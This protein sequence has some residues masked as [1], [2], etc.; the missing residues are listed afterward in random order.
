MEKSYAAVEKEDEDK[1]EEGNEWDECCLKKSPKKDGKGKEM[2]RRREKEEGEGLER[3]A[4][5]EGVE[6]EVML[7]GEGKGLKIVL[8]GRM[9]EKGREGGKD[10]EALCYCREGGRGQGG[11]RK[12]MALSW[13]GQ[14]VWM[15][16]CCKE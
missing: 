4:G 6:W 10:G 7:K 13:K 16:C 12:G 11:E 15:K 14:R 3:F 5:G 8:L 1:E 9:A 2:G